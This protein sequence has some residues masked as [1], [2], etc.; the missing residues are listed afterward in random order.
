[1][2]LVEDDTLLSFQVVISALPSGR[3]TDCQSGGFEEDFA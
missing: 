3:M 2:I 1:M